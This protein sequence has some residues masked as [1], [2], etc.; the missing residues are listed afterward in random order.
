MSGEIN[1][2][3]VDYG[4]F[5]YAGNDPNDREHFLNPNVTEISILA[6]AEEL[7]RKCAFVARKQVLESNN[8]SVD[9]PGT[10]DIEYEILDHFGIK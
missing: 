5:N 1:R 8:I 7:V 9:F 10:T 3:A 2:L 6:F 4:I